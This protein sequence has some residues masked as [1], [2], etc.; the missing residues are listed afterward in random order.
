MS[1]IKPKDVTVA[2]VRQLDR[3][4]AALAQGHISYGKFV[5]VVKRWVAGK[6]VSRDV[7][8][9]EQLPERI[10]LR[11]GGST[12]GIGQVAETLRTNY[13]SA[14]AA[15]SRMRAD[16]RAKRVARGVYEVQP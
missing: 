14:G 9:H 6:D 8:G 4:M 5:G 3:A 7:L 10:Q 13:H 16:G 11:Y 2:R 15:L 1:S 12:V